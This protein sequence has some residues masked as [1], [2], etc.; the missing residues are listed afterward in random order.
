VQVR[1]GA[2]LVDLADAAGM[3]GQEG[4]AP[5]GEGGRNL[6]HFCFNVAEFDLAKVVKHLEAHG[7][8][9]G[10][11]GRRYGAGSF[12][13]ASLGRV[14]LR[15]RRRKKTSSSC[16]PRIKRSPRARRTGSPLISRRT[17]SGTSPSRTPRPSPWGNPLA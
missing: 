7:V 13:G 14:L 9:V 11:S 3:L 16:W 1:A 2:Q 17:S 15:C 5:P 4:G 10:E 12:G 6:D 8:A